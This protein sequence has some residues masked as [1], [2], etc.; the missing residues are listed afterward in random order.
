[1]PAY[2]HSIFNNSYVCAFSLHEVMSLSEIDLD[3][4]YLLILR[5]STLRSSY[6]RV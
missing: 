6:P 2:N 5:K 3:E 4:K 1:M